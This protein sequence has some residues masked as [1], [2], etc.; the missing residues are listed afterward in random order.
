[1]TNLLNV[2]Q[3]FSVL[4]LIA[5]GML[6]VVITANIDL[7]VGALLSLAGVV[8]AEIAGHTAVG[9]GICAGYAVAIFS[10]LV[11][12]YLSTR[13][14]NLSIIVTLSM[15]TIIE[16]ISLLVTNGQPVVTLSGVLL[17]FGDTD[18]GG[19][20]VAIFVFAGA[21]LLIWV[22]LSQTRLGREL[23]AVGGNAE[24]S[25]L[26]GI[27]VKRR[28]ILA[29]V[30]S[31]VLAATAGLILLGQVASAQPTVGVGDE[32]Y[33]VGAVLIGG[34][35]VNGGMG[36]VGKTVAGVLILGLI[37]DGINLLSINAFIA[38]IVQGG[39][40]LLAILLDQWERK[41]RR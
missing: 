5:L 26:A 29:F 18:I 38:Y 24:A 21:A 23:Y 6:V 22:F 30:I 14:R 4:G 39:V 31:G 11:A 10:G 27:P 16:G 17:W 34:A 40:I 25:R 36:N 7:T 12:G 37:S 19:V 15:M 13:G 35:S 2:G 9:F 3:Q 20:P 8:M 32:M 41:G 28:V 33:A 1:M